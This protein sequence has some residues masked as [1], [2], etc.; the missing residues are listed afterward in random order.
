MPGR[1]RLPAAPPPPPPVPG[2]GLL[3]RGTH[4][5]AQP[6]PARSGPPGAAQHGRGA[7]RRGGAGK[8]PDGVGFSFPRGG[9]DPLRCVPGCPPFIFSPPPFAQFFLP[10]EAGSPILTLPLLIWIAPHLLNPHKAP[11][12]L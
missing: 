7:Q 1:G 10:S 5:L 11:P 6:G 9:R 8:I 4:R 3:R 12:N 2:D